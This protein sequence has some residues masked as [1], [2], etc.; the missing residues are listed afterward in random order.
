MR[1]KLLLIALPA[2]MVM[3][4][5]TYMEH[6]TKV[7]LFKEDTVAHEEVFGGQAIQGPAVQRMADVDADTDYKVGY[8]VVGIC[9]CLK[10][11]IQR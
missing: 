2:L 3:S 8:D 10:F 11:Q 1:N 7:D 9:D 6:A 4:S 5:C